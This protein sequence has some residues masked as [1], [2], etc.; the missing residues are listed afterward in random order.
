MLKSLNYETKPAFPA[1]EEETKEASIF[2]GTLGALSSLHEG[3]GKTEVGRGQM[4]TL[5]EVYSPL[6][7]SLFCSPGEMPQWQ[8]NHWPQCL[9]TSC[10]QVFDM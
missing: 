5:G 3:K 4:H 6:A 9:N 2:Q 10:I 8:V 7:L 1:A